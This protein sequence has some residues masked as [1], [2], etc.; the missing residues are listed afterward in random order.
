MK[1]L[2][3]GEIHPVKVLG[4]LGMIDDG[5]MDW[6][7]ICMSVND[8]I[9]RFLR[10]IDDVP[11]FLPGCLDALREWFRVYKICQGGV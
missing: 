4:I 10:D 11:K 2:L 1:Q 3:L 5:Q 6:K 8:P 7:V 9:V